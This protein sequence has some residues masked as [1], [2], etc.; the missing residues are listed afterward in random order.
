MP[1][2]VLFIHIKYSFHY[3]KPS[4]LPL[5][6]VRRVVGC[7]QKYL[8][9]KNLRKGDCTAALWL[10]VHGG[11]DVVTGDAPM[12]THQ[13]GPA[14]RA[15]LCRTGRATGVQK[16]NTSGHK[17][18]QPVTYRTSPWSTGCTAKTS[19]TSIPCAVA[20]RRLLSIR[21]SN[22]QVRPS[23]GRQG[24]R[25]VQRLWAKVNRATAQ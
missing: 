19:M 22:G 13:C 21:M 7:N 18:L 25:H 3:R 17:P 8:F 12:V 20:V 4:C 9:A 14:R 2:E 15:A 24:E 5:N 10:V 16:C 23:D 11:S 6:Y 1:A